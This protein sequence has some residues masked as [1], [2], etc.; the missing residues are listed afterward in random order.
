MPSAIRHSR[1]KKHQNSRL[2]DAQLKRLMRRAG[3]PRSSARQFEEIRDALTAD[4]QRYTKG[5]LR[6]AIA[7]VAARKQARLHAS[8]LELAAQAAYGIHITPRRRLLEAR[9]GM[10]KIAKRKAAAAAAAAATASTTAKA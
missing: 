10:A 9:R 6:R 5:I 8:D 4:A 2:P 7:K 3:A 1:V